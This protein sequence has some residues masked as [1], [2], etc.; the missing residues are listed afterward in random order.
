MLTFLDIALIIPLHMG[1]NLTDKLTS[2][3]KIEMVVDGVL[4]RVQKEIDSS[5]LGMQKL[6]ATQFRAQITQELSRQFV[7]ETKNLLQ[8]MHSP[9][10][11]DFLPELNSVIAVGIGPNV[12]TQ[13]RVDVTED[14]TAQLRIDTEGLTERD[15]ELKGPNFFAAGL[16][17]F[18]EKKRL[19]DRF[20]SAVQKRVTGSNPTVFVVVLETTGD[21]PEKM[22]A[23]YAEKKDFTAD[24]QLDPSSPE[25]AKETVLIGLSRQ[26]PNIQLE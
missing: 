11:A 22:Y 23:V 6:R 1:D 9:N 20:L 10:Q 16:K 15:K 25:N 7:R 18:V 5:P 3:G 17:D 26:L 21:N 24:S 14:I 4:P 8:F 12:E 19:P 13:I 2:P